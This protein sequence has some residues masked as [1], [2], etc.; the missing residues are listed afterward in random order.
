MSLKKSQ[1]ILVTVNW[2]RPADTIECIQSALQEGLALE[3]II[4]VD[5]GSEDDSVAQIERLYPGLEVLRAKENLGYAG[6]NNLGIKAAQK[7]KPAAILLINNDACLVPGAVDALIA[8]DWDMAVPKIFFY[9]PPDLIWSAG[10]KWRRFPPAVVMRGYLQND[11]GKYNS[12]AELEYATGC[13]LLI[14]TEVFDKVPGF[15]PRFE[16]YMEDYDF[17][18]RVREAG[19]NIG[20]VPDA[21]V[22][23]K[24]AQT[25]G[26]SSAARWHY[27]GRNTVLFFL[28]DR[29]YNRFQLWL[30]IIWV[31]LRESLKGNGRIRGPYIEGVKSGLQLIGTIQS[32]NGNNS[33]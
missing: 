7:R 12:P 11:Q 19:F 32:E 5:N 30:H 27:I 13:A 17:S 8:A 20:Y 21:V 3:Q 31:L 15:D 9:D 28:I 1:I 22:H 24:V 6:G 2:E 33:L 26:E 10:S 25:L 4:V 29:R 18:Y 16:N 14:K 23:H